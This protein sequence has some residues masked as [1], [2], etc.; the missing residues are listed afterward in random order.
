[1]STEVQ[2]EINAFQEHL[3][4]YKDVTD[5]SIP[6]TLHAKLRD[7]QKEGLKWLNFL[8]NF[9]FGGCLADDMGLG[10][11]LQIIAFILTQRE[12]YGH[13]TNLIIVLTSLLF[14]WQQELSKFAPSIK[15]LLHY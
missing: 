5:V 15:T 12:K 9:N 7:H 6:A 10:K 14:N 11:T 8:D 1:M 2:T 3:A 13:K 4:A